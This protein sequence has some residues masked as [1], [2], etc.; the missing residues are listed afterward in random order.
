MFAGLFIS[1]TIVTRVNSL[2]KQKAAEL[3]F[4]MYSVLDLHQVGRHAERIV[5]QVTPALLT[6]TG[7]EMQTYR[8]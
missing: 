1:F 4:S 6:T 7:N 5:L 2:S 8:Q 3:V